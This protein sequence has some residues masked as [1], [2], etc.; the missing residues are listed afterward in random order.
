MGDRIGAVK[1]GLLANLIAVAGDPTRRI[2][3][4]QAV[5]MVTK[6]GVVIPL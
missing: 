3:A 1:P 4:T 6:G 5:R 2:A